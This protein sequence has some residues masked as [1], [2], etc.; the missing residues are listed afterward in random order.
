MGIKR[1]FGYLGNPGLAICNRRSNGA[2]ENRISR[3][4]SHTMA[5]S[6]SMTFCLL[7]I[8]LLCSFL[9]S[10]QNPVV[11]GYISDASSGERLP[12]ATVYISETNTGTISNEYGFFSIKTTRGR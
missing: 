3:T 4:A 6:H 10:S 2:I 1:K 9:A 8:F 5:L 12:G 11:S 7:L